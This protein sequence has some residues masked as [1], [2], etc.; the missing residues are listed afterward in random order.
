MIQEARCVIVGGGAMGVGLLYY[1][2]HEGWT[3]TILVEKGELTSGSTWHAAGLIPNFIGDLN[4]AKVHQDAIAL[5]PSIEEETG[6]SAGWHGCGAI[7]LART[8]EEVDWHRYVH[9]MLNQIGV[10][11]HIISRQEVQELNPLLEDVSD[12]QTGFYTPNDGWTDPSGCTNAM[13]K[14]ARQLGCE[15]QRHNLVLAMSQ[16]SDGRWQVVTEKGLII[17]EHVVNAA[18]H[19]A[20][21]LGAM[22]GLDV[23]IVSVIHQYVVTEPLESMKNLDFEPPVT[24][25]PRSSC[26]YRREIDGLLIGPYEMANAQIYGVDGI[27]WALDFYLT[28]PDIDNIAECLELAMLRIPSWSEAGIKQIV[29]GPITHT[30]D[31]GYLMGPAPGLRNYWHCNGASIGITQGP[32]AGKYLAQWIVHGQTEINVRGMDPRRFGD[33]TG[34]KSVFAI[35]KAIDEYHEMYQ[36]RLPGEQRPVARRQK[37]NPIYDQLDA[38]GAQWQEVYG[39]ERPQYYGAAEEHSFR[40]SNAHGFVGEEVRGTRQ[41]VGIA[42]LTA[43]AKFEV[44][45]ADAAALLDRLSANKIPQRDGGIRL[46]HML[47]EHGGIESEMTVTRLASDCFYLN[48]AVIGT[49][50]DLDW[51]THHIEL[52]T[53]VSVTDVTDDYGILAVTGPRARDLLLP[54]TDADLSNEAF[55]WLTA[56]TIEIAGVSCVALRVSYVGELGWEL[57]CPIAE[58][59]QLYG[60]L[61]DAGA[62][63]DMVHFGSYAMNAMRIEKGYKAWGSELT[64]EI[65]PIEARLERFVDFSGDFIGKDATVVRRDQADPLAMVLVYCEVD[66]TDNDVRGNEGAYDQDGK[67]MGIAT[68]GAWGHTVDKSLAFVYVD[69]AFEA[70]GSTFELELLGEMRRATV[71]AEPAYDPANSALRS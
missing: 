59:A 17:C 32:G 30:P 4:M 9:A 26:Y 43:F 54:L 13:A 35:E 40:R 50:H 51:L 60:S 1:L 18:G 31:S 34:P 67:V 19:Y 24:R 44:C 42:D 53:D 10:E 47:T 46:V 16:L 49:T 6:L 37:V 62:A 58:M 71:L 70:P 14:G 39:W 36:V 56:Q 12:V 68:S 3:D 23:P 7:R 20:P 52:G 45:G 27:D 38:L 11:S 64:T 55:R 25:D 5:Y 48:S 29:S 21:Q 57:H 69:P 65:T 63:V 33:H 61:V 2:A 41:R 8:N 22:V 15:I 66:A 28:P